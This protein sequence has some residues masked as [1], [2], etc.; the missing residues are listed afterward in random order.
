MLYQTLNPHGGDLYGRP[1]TL[2]F[3][4]NTNPLGT[5]EAVR[6]AVTEAA[7]SWPPAPRRKWPKWRRATRGSICK[8]I[9]KEKA[10]PC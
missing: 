2:D 5:P 7:I 3:S 4:A 9:C 8:S 10:R 6:R 1:V